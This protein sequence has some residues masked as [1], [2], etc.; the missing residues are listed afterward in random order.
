MAQF[1]IGTSGFAYRSWIGKFYPV[2]IAHDQLLPYY[3]RHFPAVEINSTFYHIPRITTIEKWMAQTP[4]DFSFS[5]KLPRLITHIQRLQTDAQSLTRCFEPLTPC[6]KKTQPVVLLIQTPASMKADATL[7]TQFLKQ[8]PGNYRYAMEFR[9]DSWFRPDIYQ[10]LQSFNT[11]LVLSDSPITATGKR[12]WPWADEET[13]SFAYMR[14]H[15][16]RVLFTSSYTEEELQA[17]AGL[18][19]QKLGKGLDVYAF[20]NNDAAGHAVP[21]ARQLQRLVSQTHT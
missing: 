16:S 10:I 19:R 20:F 6:S 4:T 18:I 12:K 17:Y 1:F 8:L 21:N 3:A 13:A 15:G 7:L 5:F 9:H 14:F 11:A 2:S